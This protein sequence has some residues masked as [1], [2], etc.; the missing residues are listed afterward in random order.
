MAV[1]IAVTA[2]VMSVVVVV[3]VL[4]KVVMVANSPCAVVLVAAIFT[5]VETPGSRAALSEVFAGAGRAVN[6]VQLAAR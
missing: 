5:F 1:V 2:V 3:L 6:D 4:H